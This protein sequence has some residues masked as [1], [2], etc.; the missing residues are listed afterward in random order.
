MKNKKGF[1]L[2]EILIVLVVLGIVSMIVIPP[3]MR[4]YQESIARTKVKKAM[5]IYDR[6]FAKMTIEN[7]LKTMSALKT[8][9]EPNGCS[10]ARTYF[11]IAKNSSDNDG[12]K[13]K[14]SDN[15]WWDISSIDKPIISFKEGDL[16]STEA[17]KENSNKAFYLVASYDINRAAVPATRGEAIDV[18]DSYL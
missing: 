11:K 5:I 1:T 13:F 6:L 18:P 17:D 9:A 7:D 3:V 16:N 8:W 12:C 14:T 10:N 15:I 2:A 4:K